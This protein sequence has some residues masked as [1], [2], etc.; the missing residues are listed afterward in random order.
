MLSGGGGEFQ[1]HTIETLKTM[2]ANSPP[3]VHKEENVQSANNKE[4]A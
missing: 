2:G 1:A 4:P 3:Q